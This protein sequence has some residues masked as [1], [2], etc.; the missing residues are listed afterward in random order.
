MQDLSLH[1]L[2]IVENSIDAGAT[3]VEIV[4]EERIKEN[5]LKIKIKDNGRGIDKETLKKVFDPFYTTKKV[6]R[7][8]LGLSLFAQSVKEADGK[9][10]IDSKLGKGTVVKAQ[11][12]YNHI[13]RKP[14]GDMCETLMALIGTRGT[15]IDFIYRHKKNGQ[16]FVFSTRE[17]KK[18][19][20]SAEINNPEVLKFLRREIKRCSPK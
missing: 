1:I 16:E 12:C 18:R 17:I 2:D 15:N 6:R 4:I 3:K 7:V 19:L 11:M 8:G 14:L 5:L 20:G 13:D 10:K 9:I